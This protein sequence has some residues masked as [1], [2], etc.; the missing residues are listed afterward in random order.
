M[1]GLQPIKGCCRIRQFANSAIKNALAAADT[2]EIEP[3]Y[4]EP[5]LNEGLIERISHRIVHGP[6]KLR[7]RVQH[8]RQRRIWL[9]TNVVAAFDPSRR[10]IENNFRHIFSFPEHAKNG[11]ILPFFGNPL[12]PSKIISY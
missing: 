8:Q 11:C 2:S 12:F 4:V 10:T 1:L 3:Q 7:V 9:S 5:A 6:T